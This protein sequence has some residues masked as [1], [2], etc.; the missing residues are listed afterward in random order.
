[1]TLRNVLWVPIVAVGSILCWQAAQTTPPKDKNAELY[2]LFVDAVEHVDRNYVKEV[3]REDLIHSAI[4]GMLD[5]LDPYSNFIPPQNT[6]QFDQLTKGHYTGIGITVEVKDD[7]TTV[8][9]PKPHSPA[10]N[11]GVLAGDRILAVNGQNVQKKSLNDVIDLLQA[12]PGTELKLTVLHKP[13]N[14]APA[15]LMLKTAV[16]TIESVQGDIHISDDTWD[17]MLDKQNKIGY[18]RISNF[19]INTT[20]EF[21]AAIKSLLAAGMKALVIDLRFNPGGQLSTA[22]EI[23]DLFVKEG[24][25]VSTKG[26]NTE[27]RSATAKSEGTLP[28]FPVA[29]L[30]NGLSASASEIVAACLQDHKRAVIVGERTFGKGSVQNVIE[31]DE[32][33]G[34][35]K[36]ILKL[37]T[38][39][40][41]RPNGHNIH[42]FKD[43][44]ESDEWGVKPDANL[45]VRLTNEENQDYFLWRASRDTLNTNRAET[46]P[47][48]DKNPP[49]K[50]NDGKQPEGKKAPPRVR[51]S[52][53]PADKT[54]N[55]KQLNK[56][57]EYL[58]N[59]LKGS[60][61]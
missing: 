50:Q 13:Y 57:L 23:S 21:Q 38:A 48:A 14:T 36:S 28:D 52:K 6:R 32:G 43:A 4:N 30:V 18:V 24:V 27:S 39:S 53:T 2:R 12:P 46:M 42:R 45:E 49:A 8:I 9:V 26:R 34:V 15:T 22:I 10:Y 16:I 55:D 41:M 51:E 60:A 29:I 37:T 59:K 56:A 61:S 7:F 44:K 35:G 58:K 47:Q 33:E 1:M 31:L 25:I 20:P 5:D 17:F 11:A 19:V 40:Y 54:Y 3:K